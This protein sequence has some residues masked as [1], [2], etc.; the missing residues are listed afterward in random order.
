MDIPLGKQVAQPR[1]YDESLLASIPRAQGR[2][3][4]NLDTGAM[5]GLDRWNA[6]E[7]CWLNHSGHRQTGV[8][9]LVVPA[10]SP[11][12][13]E[14]KSLK[15]YLNSCFYQTFDDAQAMQQQLGEAL[16]RCAGANVAVIYE[17]LPNW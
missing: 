8:L 4:L 7:F 2:A 3:A 10:S 9:E 17:D 14:S 15:L 12:I 16:S 6:Y 11:C 1:N 5:R 13:F